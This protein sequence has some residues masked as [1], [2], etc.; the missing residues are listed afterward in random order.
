MKRVNDVKGEG[1]FAQ[2]AV[3]EGPGDRLIRAF[4]NEL[5]LH[6]TWAE[7][8]YTSLVMALNDRDMNGFRGPEQQS[9]IFFYVHAFLTQT[10][11][12]SKMMWPANSVPDNASGDFGAE[13]VELLK[14]IRKERGKRLR[15]ALGVKSSLLLIDERIRDYLEQFDTDVE[16]SEASS[17]AGQEMV[18][19]PDGAKRGSEACKSIRHFDPI[20]MIFSFRCQE[21]DLSA[22][23]LELAQVHRKVREWNRK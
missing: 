10:A 1:P 4:M 13:T 19:N 2:T 22:L 7:L 18:I 9:R 8:A 17:S 12:I 14:L 15:K 11:I 23:A 6:C 16:F 21:F 3:L 5:D 20:T